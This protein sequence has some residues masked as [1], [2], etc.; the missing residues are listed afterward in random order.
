M[1]GP[2]RQHH[3]ESSTWCRI[4]GTRSWYFHFHEVLFV[5]R[6]EPKLATRVANDVIVEIGDH[7]FFGGKLS[8]RA[9]MRIVPGFI[10][11]RM[12]RTTFVG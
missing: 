2:G 4:G 5:F 10:M 11:M 12:T 1:M 8:H 9:M 6:E 3:L 7:G